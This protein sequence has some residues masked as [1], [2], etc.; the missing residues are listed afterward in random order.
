MAQSY[1]PEPALLLFA[2]GTRPSGPQTVLGPEKHP[3]ELC[4]GDEPSGALRHNRM[5]ASI[6]LQQGTACAALAGERFR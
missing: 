6:K 1:A 4:S 5:N 2:C 3:V